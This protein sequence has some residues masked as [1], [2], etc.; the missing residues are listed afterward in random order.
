MSVAAGLYILGFALLFILN[1]YIGKYVYLY[2]IMGVSFL[3][4]MLASGFIWPT[5][6][7][8]IASALILTFSCVCPLFI[9]YICYFACL[10][11]CDVLL[12]RTDIDKE[13][14]EE[15]HKM[16]VKIRAHEMLVEEGVL[17]PAEEEEAMLHPELVNAK[18]NRPQRRIVRS[19]IAKNPNRK[20]T[21]SSSSSSTMGT[22]L[23]AL[24]SIEDSDMV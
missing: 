19:P 13:A 18:M 8:W 16:K 11:A 22:E 9:F 10:G 4:T 3:E 12:G 14:D 21:S 20:S 1:G 24:I 7:I 5:D 23:N 17:S 15:V 2:Y 6:P